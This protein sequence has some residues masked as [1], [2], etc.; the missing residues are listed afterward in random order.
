MRPRGSGSIKLFRFS[1]IQVFLHWSWFVVAIWEIS[2]R[3]GVY[4]SIGWNVAEYLMLF[5]TVTMHEFGHALAC[6]QTGGQAHDIVLW[7]L[8]GIAY[9]APPQRPGATLWTIAA[10]PLVNVVL[11][12]VFFSGFQIAR[13]TG[14]AATAPDAAQFVWD[15]ILL[16]VGLLAFNLLPIFPLDGGQL[17]RSVL[18]FG[19]GRAR[20]L[21]VA[22]VV[23][24]IGIVAGVLWSLSAQLNDGDSKG[25]IW[26]LVLAVFLGQ[27]CL[28]G[29]REAKFI[30]ALERLPR[31]TGFRC[32]T[33]GI[34]PPGGPLWRCGNCG[35][36]F[37]PYSTTGVCPH[38]AAI[39]STTPCVHCGASHPFAAWRTSEPPVI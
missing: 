30:T 14:W 20:S 16:N 31:H 1:G 2:A 4:H 29:L 19:L 11:A 12:I 21:Y 7:P 39:Q 5:A 22:A 37:D 18:W 8:G 23:G 34:A 15:M 13:K 33:C 3:M 28:I 17:L 25:L 36:P 27:R 24:I 35:Q 6:R 32:P 10:G 9:V 26:T 38:C